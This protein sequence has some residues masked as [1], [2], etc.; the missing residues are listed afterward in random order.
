MSHS[1]LDVQLILCL[2]FSVS[3]WFI[4]FFSQSYLKGTLLT[5]TLPMTKG[6]DSSGRKL[7]S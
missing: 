4:L 7:M 3:L 2:F 5:S 6:M 1:W